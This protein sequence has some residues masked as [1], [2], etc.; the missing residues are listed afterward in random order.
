MQFVFARLDRFFPDMSNQQ[1]AYDI[2]YRLNCS[3]FVVAFAD[4]LLCLWF[5]VYSDSLFNFF[6]LVLHCESPY[7]PT[8]FAVLM[9]STYTDLAKFANQFFFGCWKV[10][11]KFS[12]TS[13]ETV[14]IRWN[15]WA[16]KLPVEFVYAQM[17]A[18]FD[19]V[20]L[21]WIWAIL[22]TSMQ[23]VVRLLSLSSTQWFIVCDL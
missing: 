22:C 9:E 17:Y 11:L 7:I 3:G 19:C 16:R 12:S 15:W 8:T 14:Q 10:T 18:R 5:A 20:Q 1:Q 23:I 13:S 21:W 6:L 4:L 2:Q